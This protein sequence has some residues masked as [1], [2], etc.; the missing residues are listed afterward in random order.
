MVIKTRSD[1]FGALKELVE[2]N[3]P[4]DVPEIVSF[5][6]TGVSEKYAAFLGG[7]LDG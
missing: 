7:F 5:D 3:H 2:K 1:M 4:Y 6:L